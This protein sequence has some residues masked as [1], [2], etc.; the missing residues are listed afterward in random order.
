MTN[1]LESISLKIADSP[2]ILKKCN[3]Y[4]HYSNKLFKKIISDDKEK[5]S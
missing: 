4:K 5:N 3:F 2:K 1:K